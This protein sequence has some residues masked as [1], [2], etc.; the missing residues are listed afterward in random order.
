MFLDQLLFDEIN[1][2]TTYSFKILFEYYSK[3]QFWKLTFNLSVD[4]FDKMGIQKNSR[5]L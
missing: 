3:S 5:Y 4:L 1:Q 2:Q